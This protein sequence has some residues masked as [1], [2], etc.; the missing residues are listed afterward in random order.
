MME[1]MK[2]DQIYIEKKIAD[3][4]YEDHGPYSEDHIYRQRQVNIYLLIMVKSVLS[5][6]IP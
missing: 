6:N 4:G 2:Y 5:N 3:A 1:R